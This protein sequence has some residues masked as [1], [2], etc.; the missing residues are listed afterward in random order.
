VLPREFHA[1]VRHTSVRIAT[2]LTCS[3]HIDRRH[4]HKSV[5]FANISGREGWVASSKMAN[6]DVMR[7]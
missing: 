2:P 4:N 7:G 6:V 5:V 3:G 1:A